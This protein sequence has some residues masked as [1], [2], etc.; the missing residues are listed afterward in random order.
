MNRAARIALP[1]VIWLLPVGAVLTPT[2]L[3]P[4]AVAGALALLSDPGLR[5]RFAE[6]LRS[7]LARAIAG[8]LIWAAISCL[9]AP[10]PWGSLLLVLQVAGVMAVGGVLAAAASGLDDITRKR[11]I[12]AIAVAG[13]MLLLL[14]ASELVDRGIL[15]HAIRGWPDVFEYNPV[16]YDRCAAIAAIIAWPGVLVMTR[17][18]RLSAAVIFAVLVLVLL[19]LLEMAAARL[20]FVIGGFVYLASLWKPRGV[21]NAL[22]VGMVAAILLGPPVLVAAGAVQDLPA[23]ADELPKTASSERHRILIAQFVLAHIVERP[24]FGYGFDSSRA[25]PGGKIEKFANA[26]AL[27]LHPHNA[28]LQI[29]LE[30]GAV[31]AVVTAAVV[32]LIMCGLRVFSADRGGAAVA[33]ATFAAFATIALLSYGIWQNWWLMTGWLAA[34]LVLVAIQ[35]RKPDDQFEL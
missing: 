22:T 23:V 18:V 25:I 6:M 17:R 20:A 2:S 5:A 28:I 30:L 21:L 4:L 11:A 1:A 29:W 15:A 34:M 35:V 12:V 16:R 32:T 8:L 24:L 9:W 13:P 3:V 14:A 26:P 31:G 27:P 19:F 7:P 33:N 10:H